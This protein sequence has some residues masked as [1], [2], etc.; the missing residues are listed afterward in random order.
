MCMLVYLHTLDAQDNRKLE[1]YLYKLS[2]SNRIY[3]SKFRCTS[4]YMPIS[5]VYKLTDT[6]DTKCKICDKNEI[7]AEF[8]LLSICPVFQKD[9]N[10]LLKRYYGTFP[11]MYKFIELMSTTNTKDLR[12]LAEFAKIIIRTFQ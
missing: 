5:K 11:S 12:K 8:H 4:N 10:R 9:R 1:P 7:G 3:L 6:Y 2:T